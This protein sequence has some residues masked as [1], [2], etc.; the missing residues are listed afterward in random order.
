MDEVVE[1]DKKR[2]SWIS[3]SLDALCNQIED[4]I[5]EKIRLQETTEGFA[6]GTTDE[7]GN[8]WYGGCDPSNFIA[9]LLDGRFEWRGDYSP[10]HPI[11]EISALKRSE[12]EAINL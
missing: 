12:R 6:I 9:I 1:Y 5:G 2:G 4:V 11:Q 7:E 8:F 10:R 3:Y